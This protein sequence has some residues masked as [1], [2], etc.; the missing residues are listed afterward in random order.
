MGAE[1]VARQKAAQQ[2]ADVIRILRRIDKYGEIS[3][4]GRNST[5]A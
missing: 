4:G 1:N 3:C 2:E 5:S